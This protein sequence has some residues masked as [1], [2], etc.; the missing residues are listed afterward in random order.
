MGRRYYCDYCDVSFPDSKEGRKK[1]NDGL[2][3]QR[4]KEAHF[5]QFAGNVRIT[6]AVYYEYIL[7]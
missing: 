3:H 7:T 4:T 5:R 6:S 1:H 2:I